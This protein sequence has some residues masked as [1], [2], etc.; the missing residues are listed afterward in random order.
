LTKAAFLL[1]QTTEQLYT[2][3][4]LVFTRYKPNTHDLH[5]L[6]KM[7]NSI[8]DRFGQAFLLDNKENKKL[9]DLLRAAYVGARYKKSYAITHDELNNLQ[10]KVE[11]LQ[12][13]T[14]KL[15]EEKINSFIT[16]H[17]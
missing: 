3:I 16:Q 15:C 5:T 14:K 10:N 2:T 13:L 4:L 8:D 9:F 12:V 6:R 1:H 11:K 7:A 17:E